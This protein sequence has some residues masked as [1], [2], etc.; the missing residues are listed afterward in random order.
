MDVTEYFSFPTIFIFFIFPQVTN[1]K[2]QKVAT[3][4][5]MKLFSTSAVFLSQ[6]ILSLGID[7][8][9]RN[10]LLTKQRSAEIDFQEKR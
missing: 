1:S 10:I 4:N 5:K 7:F 9:M 2:L 8:R 3:I 6:G